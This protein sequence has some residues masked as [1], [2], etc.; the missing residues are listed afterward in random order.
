VDLLR[1]KRKAGVENKGDDE[2]IPDQEP[3]QTEEGSFTAEGKGLLGLDGSWQT[4]DHQRLKGKDWVMTIGCCTETMARR[5]S[6]ANGSF[7]A[8]RNGW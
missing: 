2:R 7:R 5:K 6:V 8:E 4:L 3:G 1:L